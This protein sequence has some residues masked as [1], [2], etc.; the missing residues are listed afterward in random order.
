[1]EF[2]EEEISGVDERDLERIKTLVNRHYKNFVRLRHVRNTV[3]SYP[4]VSF[5]KY[6][7]VVSYSD[8]LLDHDV[9][10]VLSEQVEQLKD[11]NREGMARHLFNYI[12]DR[13]SLMDKYKGNNV[14][15]R[16]Y[17][18]RDYEVILDGNGIIP[19]VP[20]TAVYKVGDELGLEDSFYVNRP[21]GQY[22]ELQVRRTW[23]RSGNDAK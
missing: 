18:D 7:I 12:E 1:M 15:V 2:K 23:E 21:T 17:E 10:E 3:L 4:S 9:E 8:A 5:K 11:E 19:H 13:R 6:D 16:M 20:G 22:Y 14:Y